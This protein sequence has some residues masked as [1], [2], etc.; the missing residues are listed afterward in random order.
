[1][2]RRCSELSTEIN[3][4]PRE[5]LGDVAPPKASH[6]P[7]GVQERLLNGLTL[8]GIGTGKIVEMVLSALPSAGITTRSAAVLGDVNRMNAMK[9]P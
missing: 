7:S 2:R 8:G 9:R 3:Q 4:M 5:P 6:L 1:M